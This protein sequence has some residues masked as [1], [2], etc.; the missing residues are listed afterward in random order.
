[1]DGG[2]RHLRA[3]VNGNIVV[4]A[5]ANVLASRRAGILDQRPQ[6]W[7]CLKASRTNVAATLDPQQT[8]RASRRA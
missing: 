3:F 5:A 7:R 4:N 6:A 2:V 8:T 1:M